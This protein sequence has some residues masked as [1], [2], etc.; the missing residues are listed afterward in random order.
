M[1]VE[2]IFANIFPGARVGQGARTFT[3]PLGEGLLEVTNNGTGSGTVT[4][5]WHSRKS[6]FALDDR[7]YM[8]NRRMLV[9]E[10]TATEDSSLIGWLSYVRTMLTVQALKTLKNAITPELFMPPESFAPAGETQIALETL[11]LACGM[12]LADITTSLM[13]N[14]FPLPWKEGSNGAW[15]VKILSCTGGRN[16][17]EGFALRAKPED[18]AQWAGGMKATVKP[19]MLTGQMPVSPYDIDER[20]LFVQHETTMMGSPSPKPPL[21]DATFHYIFTAVKTLDKIRLANL[22]AKPLRPTGPPVGT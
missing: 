18:P 19:A 20:F 14:A 4:L 13:G 22:E 15:G 3:V 8:T 10:H 9:D 12:S 21:S 11:H 7:R 5:A 1:N 2:Q 16:K 17:G 6:P